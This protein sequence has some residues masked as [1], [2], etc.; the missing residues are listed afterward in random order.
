VKTGQREFK[1]HAANCGLVH[2]V[3]KNIS[4]SVIYG[5][6]LVLGSKSRK[7]FSFGLTSYW[8]AEVSASSWFSDQ[9]ILFTP[10][11]LV[12]QQLTGA[13]FGNVL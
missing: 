13:V 4:A 6:S 9:K 12:W 3:S 5:L 1:T 7:G 10:L 8:K 2:K 11:R